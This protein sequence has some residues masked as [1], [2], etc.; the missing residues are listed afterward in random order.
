MSESVIP[1]EFTCN[2]CGESHGGAPSFSYPAP[3]QYFFVPEGEREERVKLTDDVCTITNPAGKEDQAIECFIRATIEIPIVGCSENITWGVWV[4]QSLES[5]EDYVLSFDQ[6][7]T[8]MSS[9]GWLIV[10]L[11]T[12]ASENPEEDFQYLACDVHWG[13]AQNRPT[14]VVRECDHPLYHDQRNGISLERAIAIVEKAI[15]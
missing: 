11:P 2:T 14:L 12:Y 8:G 7:Q 5:F 13:N 6:D 3:A 10:T 9:F 1:F 4:S 15:H